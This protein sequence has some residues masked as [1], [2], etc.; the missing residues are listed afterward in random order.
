MAMVMAMLVVM[1][2]MV[3]LMVIMDIIHGGDVDHGAG[4]MEE[5]ERRKA[6]RTAQERSRKMTRRMV[7]KC[8][9]CGAGAFR[10][11]CGDGGLC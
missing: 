8:K 9:D 4:E 6:W 5:E 10:R 1:V 2:V 7:E 3:L 11:S